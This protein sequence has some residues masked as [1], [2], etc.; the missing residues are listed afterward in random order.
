MPD[1]ANPHSVSKKHLSFVTAKRST[2]NNPIQTLIVALLMVLASRAFAQMD[3]TP[4]SNS[5]FLD[6]R[7]D[8]LVNDTSGQ[9]VAKLSSLP[10]S[11]PN[12]ITYNPV[13]TLSY[14]FLATNSLGDSGKQVNTNSATADYSFDYMTSDPSGGRIHFTIDSAVAYKNAFGESNNGNVS[15]LNTYAITT[16]PALHLLEIYP[17]GGTLGKDLTGGIIFGYQHSDMSL[18]N[19]GKYSLAPSNAFSVSPSFTLSTILHAAGGPLN[20]YLTN[21]N[22]TVTF[23]TTAAYQMQWVD[24]G[25]A[26]GGTTNHGGAS[27]SG[28]LSYAFNQPPLKGLSLSLTTQFT[29]D[30]NQ[31][32]TAGQTAYYQGWMDFGCAVRYRLSVKSTSATLKVGYDYTA[33]RSDTYANMVSASIAISF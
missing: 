24:T 11:Q 30:V 12:F 27:L 15:N 6:N 14:G 18:L 21:T 8:D 32:L 10:A 28:Q 5:I 33:F 16:Q 25:G 13:F 20:H 19:S 26:T 31:K 22:Q 17:F 2:K 9:A 4:Q 23:L 29:H 7:T 1:L 3:F